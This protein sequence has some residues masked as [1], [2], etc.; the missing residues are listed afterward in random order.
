[1]HRRES[2]KSIVPQREENKANVDR[3]GEGR[4]VFMERANKTKVKEMKGQIKVLPAGESFTPHWSL[5]YSIPKL[6]F[7]HSSTADFYMPHHLPN[8]VSA[9]TL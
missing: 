9:P 7:C 8:R 5:P 3:E 2:R 4:E 6:L 1:M